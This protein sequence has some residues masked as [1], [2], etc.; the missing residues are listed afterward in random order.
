MAAKKIL[1]ID[2]SKLI[3]MRVCNLLETAGFEVAELD[4][5]EDFFFNRWRYRDVALILLDINL[6]GRDGLSMLQEMNE[7]KR[8][9]WP[10]VFVISSLAD[11]NTIRSALYYGAKD[12]ILKPF[13]AADFLGKINNFI[14]SEQGQSVREL[15]EALAEEVRLLNRA[16]IKNGC[17]FF[18]KEAAEKIALKCLMLGKCEQRMVLFNHDYGI[19]GYTFRHSINVAVL[20]GL[21][22]SWLGL[23]EEKTLDLVRA[24]LLH[25]LGKIK[26]PLRILNKRSKLTPGEMAVMRTHPQE[27]VKL[28]CQE[29]YAADVLKGILEHH[30]RIDGSGYPKRLQGREM[31]LSAKVVAVADVYD[32]MMSNRAYHNGVTPFV[33]IEDLS[34]SMI[35][36]LD[37]LI[38]AVF[39]R[40]IKKQMLGERVIL[41]NGME[42][43]IIEF[44]EQGFAEAILQLPDGR[45]IAMEE[46]G[47]IAKWK[48]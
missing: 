44:E 29:D 3:R 20:C 42:A 1:V 2:D 35:G 11:K 39:L 28:L 7:S 16:Y 5:V 6:P 4:N 30:E 26:I 15:Y 40:N 47:E 32:A 41:A 45:R 9:R 22:G 13:V 17:C 37:P 27:G 8:E 10:K 38:C 36:K 21:L 19:S 18:P 46:S 24:G 33:V 34:R 48:T 31:A 23:E 25:D 12:Y 14:N 43:K